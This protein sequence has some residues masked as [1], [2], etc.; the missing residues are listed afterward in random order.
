MCRLI[1]NLVTAITLT[2]VFCSTLTAAPI[3][4]MEA[5]PGGVVHIPLGPEK[6]KRVEYHHRPVMLIKKGPNWTA[7]VG[8]A[9]A[10]PVKT[11]NLMVTAV[12]GEQT[13]LQFDLHDKSYKS[14][15]ITLKNK[16]QV[17]PTS[18]DLKR[19]RREKKQMIKAFQHWSPNINPDSAFILPAKGPFSSPFGLRRFFNGEPRKPH[20]GLDIAADEGSPLKAPA[21]GRILLTGHFFFNGNTVMIDH[22]QGLISMLCHLQQIDVEPGQMVHQGERIGRVGHTGRATGP[23]VHWSV[24]LNNNRIDPTLFF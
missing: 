1:L 8:I 9:L 11:Q 23:H 2:M 13:T 21:S 14:Q 16:R 5:V 10:T 15:H 20:S 4:R 12:N 18:L 17:N 7:I 3:P 22:G 6:P 19:I 24:S